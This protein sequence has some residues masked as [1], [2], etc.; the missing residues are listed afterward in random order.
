MISNAS[1]E[2]A[3]S[4]PLPSPPSTFFTYSRR[5]NKQVTLLESNPDPTLL[6]RRRLDVEET[7]SVEDEPNLLVLVQVIVVEVLYEGR[8]NKSSPQEI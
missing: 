3:Q 7:R 5:K 2:R 8:L 4:L 6:R 1:D